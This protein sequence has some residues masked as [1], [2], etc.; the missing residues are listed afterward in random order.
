MVMQRQHFASHPLMQQTGNIGA[1]LQ[2]V[3]HL[4]LMVSILTRALGFGTYNGLCLGG[5]AWKESLG[6]F[7][8]LSWFSILLKYDYIIYKIGLTKKIY[9][10]GLLCC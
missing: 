3:G 2:L 1:V 8:N 10:I 6:K 4:H 7:D 9:E 5:L